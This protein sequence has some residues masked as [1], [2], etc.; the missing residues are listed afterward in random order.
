MG[1]GGQ[2]PPIPPDILGV[3]MAEIEEEITLDIVAEKFY[4]ATQCNGDKIVISSLALSQADAAA[5]TWLINNS[6]ET[7]LEVQIKVK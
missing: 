5:L 4:F 1:L 2:L 3:I 6:P 7:V